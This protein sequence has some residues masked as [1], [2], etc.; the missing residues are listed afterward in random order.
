MKDLVLELF[1]VHLHA[2]SQ[3]VKTHSSKF[4]LREDA[5]FEKLCEKYT[6]MEIE[7]LGL[8]TGRLF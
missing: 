8:G 5:C 6:Y 7:P 4:T 2:I 3:Y 1:L